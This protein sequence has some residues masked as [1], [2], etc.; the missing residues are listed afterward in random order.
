M[1]PPALHLVLNG[2]PWAK[3]IRN[4]PSAAPTTM[5]FADDGYDY[6]VYE[7]VRVEYTL[8]GTF[9]HYEYRR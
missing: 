6:A 2:G 1:N 9:Y 3:T 7:Q 4:W 8:D 5:A